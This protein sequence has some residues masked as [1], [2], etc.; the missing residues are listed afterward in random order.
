[1][2]RYS[3]EFL[4]RVQRKLKELEE[5]DLLRITAAIE[6]LR[7]NPVPPKALKLKGREGFRIRVG[8]FRIIYSVEGSR[9]VILVL[10][11]GPRRDI[12]TR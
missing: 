9:L 6:L 5:K 10:D 4:P 8:K 3:V 1:M 2:I 11:V 12:Y 7:D